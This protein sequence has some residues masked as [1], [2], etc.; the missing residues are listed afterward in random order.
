M[1][2][3][4]IIQTESEAYIRE[5][6]LKVIKKPAF[7]PFFLNHENLKVLRKN[8][9]HQIFGSE[10]RFGPKMDRARVNKLVQA[11]CDVFMHAAL[12]EAKLKHM[13]AAERKRLEDKAGTE[14]RAAEWYEEEQRVLNSTNISKS[15]YIPD[16]KEGTKETPE[17]ST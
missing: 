17:A 6:C 3:A 12:E 4:E 14:Q 7:I 11:G 15:T 10:L 9:R 1:D 13:S 8:L 16:A 5:R 2:L